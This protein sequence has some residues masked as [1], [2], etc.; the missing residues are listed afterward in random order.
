MADEIDLLLGVR[1]AQMADDGLEVFKVLGNGQPGRIGRAVEGTPSAALVE[2]GHEKVVLKIAV[3]IAEQRPLWAA[4]P[5]VQPQQQRCFL[6]AVDFNVQFSVANLDPLRD[7]DGVSAILNAASRHKECAQKHKDTNCQRADAE[8]G[9]RRTNLLHSH[10]FSARSVHWPGNVAPVFPDSQWTRLRPLFAR[11]GTVGKVR[12]LGRIL[13]LSMSRSSIAR[14]GNFSRVHSLLARGRLVSVDDR[15]IASDCVAIRW[16]R[17]VET[18]EISG[19]RA[20]AHF[21]LFLLCFYFGFIG[22][23]KEKLPN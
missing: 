1:A 5:P 20:I 10:A 2:I 4:W 3:E 8:E 13:R 7:G 16:D 14:C 18:P 9:I 21:T 15:R 17:S 19:Q 22:K 6:W 11:P 23:P 12:S